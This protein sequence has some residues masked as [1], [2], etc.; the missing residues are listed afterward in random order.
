VKVKGFYLNKFKTVLLVQTLKYLTWFRDG[1]LIF[2]SK[3]SV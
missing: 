1:L 3:R 2:E